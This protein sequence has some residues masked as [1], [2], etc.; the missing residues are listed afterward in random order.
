MLPFVAVT[1]DAG[2][3]VVLAL[4]V[5]LDLYESIVDVFVRFDEFDLYVIIAVV[6]FVVFE[7]IVVLDF[8][9]PFAVVVGS[10]DSVF[11]VFAVVLFDVVVASVVA[12]AAVV[13]VV[14]G[15]VGKIV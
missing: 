10:L 15:V 8:D 6:H 13:A 7:K 4:V 9:G 12:A 2:V 14:V 5:L 1:A 3:V 11:V